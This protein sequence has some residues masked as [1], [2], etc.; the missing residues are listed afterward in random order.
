[1]AYR[2]PN[3]VKLIILTLAILLGTWSQSKAD[4]PPAQATFEKPAPKR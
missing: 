4:L 3:D 2:F 1:M